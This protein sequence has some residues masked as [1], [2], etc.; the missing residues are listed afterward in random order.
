VSLKALAHEDFILVRR[1]GA[2]G[3]YADIL[4]ACRQAGFVPRI[5]REVPRMVSGINLVAAGLG[6]TLVPASMQRYDQVGT[7][8][9]TL[10]NPSKLSAPL[11]LAYPTALHNSAAT[12]F[13]QLVKERA[14][15]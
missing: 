2:P 14:A 5:A 15:G 12:R 11:H 7:V 9:C 13:I 1:P 3:M 4:A 6:V 10:A 8:Y